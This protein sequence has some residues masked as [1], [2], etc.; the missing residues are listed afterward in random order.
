MFLSLIKN[1]L[2][3]CLST[4]KPARAKLLIIYTNTFI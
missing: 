2:I 1:E 3:I 4:E